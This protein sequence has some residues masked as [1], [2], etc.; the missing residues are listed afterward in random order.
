[1][2]L[3]RNIKR[4]IR[5]NNVFILSGF[6]NYSGYPNGDVE[7]ENNLNSSLVK[8]D[9]DIG[10]IWLNWAKLNDMWS[11]RDNLFLW[12]FQISECSQTE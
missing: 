4:P 11:I 3:E 2:A 9:I 7:Y 8:T 10:Q 6:S 5:I 1:M 12:P